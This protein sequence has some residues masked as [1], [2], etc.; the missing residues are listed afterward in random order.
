MVSNAYGALRQNKEVSGI[1]VS[2]WSVRAVSL[3][4]SDSVN[5]SI[6]FLLRGW[7]RCGFRS[8]LF[9]KS[10]LL[11]HICANYCTNWTVVD[12]IGKTDFRCSSLCSDCFRVLQASCRLNCSGIMDGTCGDKWGVE[13]LELH[14]EMVR[15]EAK[16]SL[17]LAEHPPVWTRWHH[18]CYS[19]HERT[20][21]LVYLSI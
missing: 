17:S 20:T 3:I 6:N 16:V 13:E 1:G 21:H 15:G 9:Y 11:A 10:T 5:N 8:F 19:M 4:L 12:M 18:H 2:F 14:E 7:W